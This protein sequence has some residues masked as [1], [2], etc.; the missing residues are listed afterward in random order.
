[1]RLRGGATAGKAEPMEFLGYWWPL[2]AGIG[3]L[4][5]SAGVVKSGLTNVDRRLGELQS[6]VA[7]MQPTLTAVDKSMAVHVANF[8]AHEKL[9]ELRFQAIE[10]EV[11]RAAAAG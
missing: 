7:A 5:I 8:A 9:D 3:G 1:M 2:I 4:L 11:A 6:T 10:R